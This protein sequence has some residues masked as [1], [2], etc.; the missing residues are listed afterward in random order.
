MGSVS[1]KLKACGVKVN[2]TIKGVAGFGS[3]ILYLTPNFV[4][5]NYVLTARHV[6]QET[7]LSVFAYQYVGDIEICYSEQGKLTR[8]ELIKKAA[9][10]DKLIVF[11]EDFAILVVKKI[12]TIAFRQILVSDELQEEEED[13]F[14]WA[15]FSANKDELHRFDLHRNDPAQKRLKLPGNFDH[16]YLPGMSGAGVF[17]A[18]KSVLYGIITSYPNEEFQNDTIDCALISFVEINARLK[19]L[20]LVELDIKSSGHKREV[21]TEVVDIHQAFI[22]NVCLDLE[23]ARKRLKTDIA[24]DWYYDPLKYIDLLNQSYLFEQLGPYFGRNDYAAKEAE[25]FYVPKKKFTLRLALVSPF[26]D[27]MLY[28]AAVGTLADKLD[29]AM[30]PNVYSARYNRFSERQ[31]ILNGVEQWKKMQYRLAELAVLKSGAGN[32]KYGCLI[33]ID[34]LNFY[35]NISKNLLHEKILRICENDNEHNAAKLLDNILHKFSTKELGLPQNSDASSLLASFYLNQV[36]IFMSHHA[37]AYYRFMDDIRI[38]CKDKY[39]ARKVLQT[40]EFELRRCYLSVNSQKTEIYT[41]V[42]DEAQ[43]LGLNEKRRSQL[44]HKFDIDL[45][46]IARLRHSQNHQYLNEAFHGCIA[47][48][49]ENL[50]SGDE[51]SPE[52]AARKLN[53]AFN[54]ISSLAVQ[55]I[56]LDDGP[57]EFRELILQAAASLTDKPWLTPEVCRV[58]SLLSTPEIKAYFLDTLKKIVLKEKYNTYS[59]QTYQIWLLLAKH[60]CDVSALKKFAIKQIEKND[61]TNK[62]VIAA[63]VIYMCSVDNGY[64]RVVLRKFVEGFTRDYFE[65]RVALIALRA[66][67]TAII[68]AERIDATLT[69]AHAFTHKFKNKDL[70]FVQGFEE[71]EEDEID[72]LEQLYSI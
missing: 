38:F 10:K 42:D 61:D 2:T 24:D 32:F 63:M 5:Y 70:V 30:I 27:R 58:L 14:S 29:R 17:H 71:D 56:S 16:R 36:D 46:K 51:V 62:A 41:L 34:L 35:D 11:D 33:E 49:K 72:P 69:K 15:T 59:F 13:F 22:N 57:V 55:G 54:T 67:K 50:T 31:L 28:M 52:E 20:K 1:E 18:E 26:V 6:F 4:D 3:G 65:N 53:Y 37:P 9:V 47:L 19:A 23:K 12:D 68:P 21:G 45:N 48:L 43:P 40:F 7:A 8:L 64:R 60:K 39:E 66:F 25:R 44:Q